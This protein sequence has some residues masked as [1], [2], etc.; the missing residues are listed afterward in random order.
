LTPDDGTVDFLMAN[1]P[2]TYWQSWKFYLLLFVWSRTDVLGYLDI[3]RMHVLSKSQAR[4]L[5]SPHLKEF[6]SL[7]DLGAGSGD[8]T[9]CI[10]PLFDKVTTTEISKSMLQSLK[11]KGYEV[12]ESEDLSDGSLSGRTFDC[13]ACLNLLDR[14]DKPLTLLN[15]LKSFLGANGVVLIALA[16][17]FNPWVET[18]SGYIRPSELMDVEAESFEEMAN[19]FLENVLFKNGFRL[20]AFSKAPYLSQGDYYKELYALTDSIWVV[21]VL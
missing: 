7:L 9:D 17:P 11:L 21:S 2:T 12:I 6:G 10:A 3:G 20:R 18:R 19:K 1:T 15:Q 14:C 16:V 8:V 5:L 13:I 4:K